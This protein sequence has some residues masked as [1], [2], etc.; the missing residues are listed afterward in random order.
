[1]GKN[2]TTPEAWFHERAT[3]YVESQILFH[4]S[5]VGVFRL[6]ARDKSGATPEA[7]AQDLGLVPSILTTLL[8]Y[9]VAVDQILVQEPD[10]R[11]RFSAFGW[12]LSERYGKETAEGRQFNFFDVRVGA[13]GPVWGA[14]SDMMRGERVYGEDLHR[15]GAFAERGLYAT[16]RGMAPS[17]LE[18]LPPEPLT[19]LELGVETGLLECVGKAR[20]TDVLM[21]LDR[22]ARAIEECKSQAAREEIHGLTF[23]EADLFDVASWSRHLPRDKPGVLYSIHMHEFMAAGRTRMVELVELLCHHLPGWKLV[24]FEQPLPIM[25]NK[26]ATKESLWMASHSNV[27]IHHL[28]KNGRILSMKDWTELLAEGGGLEIETRPTGYLDYERIETRLGN[29]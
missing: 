7:L 4:L 20:S 21:G 2:E 27:L 28:I 13:Y 19:V 10:G 14:L 6:L 9:V 29:A 16:A 11:V 17:L 25:A 15:S 12:A 1:M 23:I 5:Q 22:S 24:F 8:E 3:H 26:E 18:A